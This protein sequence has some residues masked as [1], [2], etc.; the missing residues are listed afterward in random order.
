M[1]WL[2]AAG[3]VLAASSAS[4]ESCRPPV[5]TEGAV[6]DDGISI[7]T[8]VGRVKAPF[9][10]SELPRV[11]SE[12]TSARMLVATGHYRVA[13]RWSV[14][15]RVPTAPSSV[16]QPGGSYVAENIFGNLELFAETRPRSWRWGN[17]RIRPALRTGLGLPTAGL[18]STIAG[19]GLTTAVFQFCYSHLCLGM[20][21][22]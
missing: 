3:V 20:R 13:E 5:C 10:T 12:F 19:L 21:I 9:V 18:G 8:R 4:G 15:L 11:E 17:A 2:I 14:G 22:I 6:A 7:L 1:R 16:R